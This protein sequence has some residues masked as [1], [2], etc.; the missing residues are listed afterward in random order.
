[1]LQLKL[2]KMVPST[3]HILLTNSDLS[4][5]LDAVL[6]SD[7]D[8]NKIKVLSEKLNKLIDNQYEQ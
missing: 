3:E 6:N 2:T 8:K 1:M 5:M 7:L 4:D